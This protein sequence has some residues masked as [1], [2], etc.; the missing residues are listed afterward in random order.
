MLQ[1]IQTEREQRYQQQ[2]TDW[3]A[4]GKQGGKPKAPKTLPPLTA[5]ELADLPELPEGWIYSKLGAI[6]DEPTYG[7]AK[8]CDYETMEIGV[9]RIPNVVSG[10][11]DASDLK[12]AQFSDAEIASYKL[13][14]GDILLIRSN[15]SVSIV[16][17]C[18]LVSNADIEYLYAGYL[19]M[20]RPNQT[21]IVPAYLL[22]LFLSHSVRKQIEY[23]AK[24]TSGVNNINSGEIQSL[25]IAVCGIEEQIQIQT[26]LDSKL[27]VCDQLDQT[28][29]TALQQAEA[30]RQSILK[31]AFSGQLVPQD[32]NDEPASVLLER[33]QAETAALCP[34]PKRTPIKSRSPLC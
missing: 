30:L 12:Y 22:N 17:R 15:G 9:L 10:K 16:G 3:E 26:E 24:S 21:V 18:A 23:K 31:K 33:I 34:Q 5:E 25:V 2:L 27:S 32:P 29:T 1:R 20:L 14:A 6:I 8:K 19:I 11:I 7:T 4:N 13:N 28:L